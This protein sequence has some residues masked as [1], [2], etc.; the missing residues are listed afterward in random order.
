MVNTIIFYDHYKIG[1][2]VQI[3]ALVQ[4]LGLKYD[5]H[6]V[7][8]PKPWCWLTPYMFAKLPK[9]LQKCLPLPTIQ[10]LPS[11]IFAAGRQS[12]L[13]ALS[14]RHLCHTIVLLNPRV[15]CKYFDLV[16]APL[17]DGL[18]KQKNVIE[19]VGSLHG[20]TPEGL[21][22]YQTNFFDNL[23]KPYLSIL[24][25]GNSKH[26]TYK[27]SL[28][29]KLVH[30]IRTLRISHP[31]FSNGSLLITPSRRT[32]SDCLNL[33]RQLIE[34]IPHF[35]WDNSGENPYNYILSQADVIVVT[36]D[37][38]SMVSESCATGKNVLIYELP[39]KNKKFINFF[40]TLYQN[41]HAQPFNTHD[42]ILKQPIVLQERDRILPL[43]QQR[44]GS[45]VSLELI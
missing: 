43:V 13:Y 41:K 2:R 21:Q 11:L 32:P 31:E 37:S 45:F 33:L 4:G 29:K 9:C 34:D 7:Q 14:L 26:F 1:T 12:V 22:S 30:D 24:L 35:I 23:P 39:I 36:G 3:E 38:I 27:Q 5:L 20:I 17:H 19:F 16:L 10:H 15:A 25:G 44:I 8:L 6:P 28:I 18:S 42:D 40:S